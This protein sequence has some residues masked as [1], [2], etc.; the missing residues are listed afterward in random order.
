MSPARCAEFA[1]KNSMYLLAASINRAA[2][3]MELI[4][5]VYLNKFK[6]T[7]SHVVSGKVDRRC[8]TMGSNALFD[9]CFTK[10]A[11]DCAKDAIFSVQD[12]EENLWAVHAGTMKD[13]PH[14]TDKMTDSHGGYGIPSDGMTTLKSYFQA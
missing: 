10:R 4:D 1:N 7:S 13:D 14:A 11:S 8:Y 6:G 5:D 9:V 12:H 3:D 2:S